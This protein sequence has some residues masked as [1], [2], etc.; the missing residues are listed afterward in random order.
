MYLGVRMASPTQD[1]SVLLADNAAAPTHGPE[2]GLRN[3]HSPCLI[4]DADVAQ[5]FFD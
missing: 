1:F 3:C 5:T 4:F 2:L